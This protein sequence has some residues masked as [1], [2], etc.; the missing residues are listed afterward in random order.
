MGQRFDFHLRTEIWATGLRNPFRFSFDAATGRLFCADVGQDKYEEINIVTGGGDYGWSW[1]EGNTPSP[2]ALILSH[3]RPAS[4][5]FLH[6]S[7]MTI[8]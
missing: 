7:S 4:R 2:A 1:R 8:R 3:R 6:L 5:P